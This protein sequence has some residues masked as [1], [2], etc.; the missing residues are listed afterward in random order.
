LGEF[1]KPW[2][3][4]DCLGL[5]PIARQILWRPATRVLPRVGIAPK[6]AL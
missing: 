4:S 3:R 6:W 5:M 1:W 2:Q